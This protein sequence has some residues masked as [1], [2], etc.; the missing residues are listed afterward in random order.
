MKEV[1][2]KAASLFLPLHLFIV[3]TWNG[4]KITTVKAAKNNGK[5][6]VCMTR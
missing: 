1:V 4:L 3:Q 6:N 5:M 2:R